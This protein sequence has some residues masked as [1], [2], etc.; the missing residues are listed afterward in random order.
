M[1]F[2][3]HWHQQAGILL[4]TLLLALHLRAR[5]A[6]YW[7][8]ALMLAVPGGMLLNV[9]L[10]YTFQR[11]RPRFDEP[12]LTLASYSFP[13]GHTSGAML[14]YGL[15]AA[16]LVCTLPRP[17]ARA[18]VLGLATL[19]VALVALSRVY[20]GV[21]YLSDVLAGIA[22]GGAWFAVCITVISTL[23]RSRL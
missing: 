14:F 7:L 15:L 1:L 16:Y 4:M 13:S 10:K 8:L 17:G 22:F 5:R 6:N 2:V 21:H 12:L 20:L 19:M 18:A 23:R 3:T 9:L 11:A